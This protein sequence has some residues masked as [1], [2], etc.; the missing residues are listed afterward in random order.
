MPYTGAV[1]WDK[2][3]AGAGPV[4]AQSEQ[5]EVKA[6]AAVRNMEGRI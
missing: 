5:V 3:A 2:A 4:D 1:I 6:E